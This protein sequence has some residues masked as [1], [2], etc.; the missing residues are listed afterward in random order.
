MSG[1]SSTSTP[2]QKLK[3][4]PVFRHE[5][6]NP[7]PA[8]YADQVFVVSGILYTLISLALAVL[9]VWAFVDAL[10]YSP[11]AYTAVGRLSKPQWL[12]ITGGGL[13]A[14]LLFPVIGGGALAVI[15]FP[16]AGGLGFLGL[17]GVV[18]AIVYLVDT[19][20]KLADISRGPRY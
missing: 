2:G 7:W 1:W 5:F 20:K 6:E 17:A 15:G 9:G 16:T 12:G 19:R 3:Y 10:R 13:V 18:A 8:A 11:Q 4:Q 14:Q